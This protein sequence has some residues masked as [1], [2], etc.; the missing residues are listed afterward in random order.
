[1]ESLFF[2]PFNVPVGILASTG[3]I[4]NI[5]SLLKLTIETTGRIIFT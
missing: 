3:E 5:K 1:M 2:R 4:P